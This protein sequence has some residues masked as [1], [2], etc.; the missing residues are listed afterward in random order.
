MRNSFVR[1]NQTAKRVIKKEKIKRNS[2]KSKRHK[3][4]SF[5]D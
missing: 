3:I 1:T 4:E 2:N 5:F